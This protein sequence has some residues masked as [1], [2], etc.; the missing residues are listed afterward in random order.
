[1][2]V[3]LFT[4][5]SELKLSIQKSWVTP[6]LV[7]L[8]NELKNKGI[9]FK[10]HFWLSDEWFCPDG[11]TGFA[12]PF[13]IVNKK[14]LKLARQEIFV[15]EGADER[16][17]MK[18]LRHECAHALDNAFHLRKRKRRQKLFGISSKRYPESYKPK[19]TQNKF[20]KHIDP[21]YAQAHPEEDWAETFAVWLDPKSD[22]RKK[23]KIGKVR[24]KLDYMEE[25]MQ[26][27]KNK[28][29][30]CKNND[31]IDSYKEIKITLGEFFEK[32]RRGHGIHKKIYAQKLNKIFNGFN[33][34]SA[35]TY[36]KN[37]RKSIS[38]E[39]LK[40]PNTNSYQVDMI[41]G[42]MI[43]YCSEHK[44]RLNEDRE[45]I[46]RIKRQFIALMRAGEDK[47]I[48]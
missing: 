6:Y 17:I 14:L 46:P 29:Q 13:Y 19:I 4:P 18:Y 47:V 42:K 32:R 7:R 22:W 48:M 27:I 45:L 36:L 12:L 44:L 1:M 20:V 21:A 3:L 8:Q 43:A 35:S 10:P 37:N 40:L 34:K 33:R 5:I 2:D 9:R 28:K 11:I 23:Y 41:L 39:L 25:V 38:K 30:I 16:V 24:E 15:V 26:S 31:K